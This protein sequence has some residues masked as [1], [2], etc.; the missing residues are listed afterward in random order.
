MDQTT[1]ALA[2]SL[3]IQSES[4]RAAVYRSPDRSY[5]GVTPTRL[6]NG[7]L[8]WPADAFQRIVESGKRK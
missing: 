8:L 1:A 4:I 5:Y 7:R 2:A 3:G 6:P